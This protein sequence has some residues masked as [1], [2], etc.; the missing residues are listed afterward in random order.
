M[1]ENLPTIADIQTKELKLMKVGELRRVALREVWAHEAHDFTLWLQNNL[2]VLNDQLGLELISA[3]REQAAGT[4]S[5][6]LVAE[7][8]FGN[9]IIIENQL[10]KTNHDH[11]GKLLTYMVAVE[12]KAA[13]WIASDPR[14]E[15]VAVINWLNESS[16][17]DFYLIKVEAIRIDESPPAALLTRIVGPSLEARV[18]G[19][20][21]KDLAERHHLRR[22][23]WVSFLERAGTRIKTFAG[24]SPT[25]GTWLVRA[26]GKPGL[27]WVCNI[28]QDS[29]RAMLNIDGPDPDWNLRA[30]QVLESKREAIEA[31]CECELMWDVEEGR[32]RCGVIYLLPEGGYRNTTEEWPAIQDRMI[33]ALLALQRALGPHLSLLPAQSQRKSPSTPFPHEV[34]KK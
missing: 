4:F 30:L 1:N 8:S 31:A 27:S 6:D 15:H 26:M 21:K 11:L 32:K 17:A 3:D 23:F 12:A 20:T 7:D 16:S 25:D 13:I 29:A 33:E 18:I 9:A 34:F 22:A 2:D 10:E 28:H 14:P 24:S 5:V 19:Q